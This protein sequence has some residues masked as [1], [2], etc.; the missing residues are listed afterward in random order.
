MS[1]TLKYDIPGTDW[2][3]SMADAYEFGM[4]ALFAPELEPPFPLSIEIGFGRGEFMLELAAKHPEMRFV[5][6]EVS[7]K[8]VLKM[9]RKVARSELDNVR[10]LA[11]KGEAVV[12]DCVPEGSV[13]EIWVNFSDPWPKAAHAHRRLFQP[14]FVE[15]AAIALEPSGLLRVATDDPV[16]AEQID[17]VLSGEPRLENIYAPHPWVDDVPG[18]IMTSYER[19]WRADGRAIHFFDYRRVS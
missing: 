10:L 6:V 4:H 8:R 3:R 19:D 16:Y 13:H 9:A 14:A 2:R 18:R 1:R 17:E 15:S 12:G 11:G 5:A 7:W